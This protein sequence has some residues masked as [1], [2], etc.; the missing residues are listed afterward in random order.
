VEAPAEETDGES[1]D[2]SRHAEE[3]GGQADGA[4]KAAFTQQGESGDGRNE[5]GG[6]KDEIVILEAESPIHEAPYKRR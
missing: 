2:D 3:D 5:Q 6:K 1:I 4:G